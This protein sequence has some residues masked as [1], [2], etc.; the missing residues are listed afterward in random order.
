LF[1]QKLVYTRENR[2]GRCIIKLGGV[3]EKAKMCDFLFG[4]GRID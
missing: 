1:L 2:L 3:G 4:S